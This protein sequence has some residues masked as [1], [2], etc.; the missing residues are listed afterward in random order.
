MKI[1]LS[2]RGQALAEYMPLIPPI[3]LLSVLILVPLSDSAG[4]V[5]CQMVNAMEPEK[6]QVASMEDGEDGPLPRGG[7]GEQPPGEE[8]EDPCVELEE[9]RGGSQCDHSSL[10][11]LL[12]GSRHGVWSPSASITTVV[13]KAGQGYFS[14]DMPGSSDGCYQVSIQSDHVE[15]QKIGRGRGCQ[16]I[17]HVEAWEAQVCHH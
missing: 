1:R 13:I 10:C 14:F 7:P 11:T 5:Y 2:E 3:L 9:S 4:D 17:S 12:P 6:C 8:P 15:W 16:D